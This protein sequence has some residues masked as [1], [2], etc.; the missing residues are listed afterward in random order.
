M[1]SICNY[2]RIQQNLFVMLI[3][4]DQ[5]TLKLTN[6]HYG[7]FIQ[8][9]DFLKETTMTVNNYLHRMQINWPNLQI[10]RSFCYRPFSVP[11]ELQIEDLTLMVISY[12][13]Y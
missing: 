4:D 12:E 11:L 10:Q 3:S 5:K 1:Q 2:L 8:E 7:E 9:N 13:I 6:I